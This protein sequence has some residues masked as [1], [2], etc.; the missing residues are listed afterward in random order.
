MT[1]RI[2]FELRQQNRLTGCIT[3][4]IHY[5]DFVTET[6]QEFITYTGQD[7]ILLKKVKNLFARLYKRRQVIRLIGVRFTDLISGVY[8][9][10]LYEDRQE[11][12][13]LY[14][15]VDCVKKPPRCHN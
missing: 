1:E 8:Q 9:P 10:D 13:R 14:Q 15:A 6:K 5:S 11:F 2:A 12:L 7:H 4:K 3:I